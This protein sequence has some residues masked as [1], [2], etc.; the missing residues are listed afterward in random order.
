MEEERLRRLRCS[1]DA[2]RQQQQLQFLQQL[3]LRPQQQQ[4]SATPVRSGMSPLSRGNMGGKWRPIGGTVGPQQ[5]RQPLPG[6]LLNP[7]NG[8]F[9]N[10]ESRGMKCSTGPATVD[11]SSS[12]QYTS[13]AMTSVA[14]TITSQS[15]MAAP[16][17]S[18]QRQRPVISS[19]ALQPPQGA[20]TR[21]MGGLRHG[22]SPHSYI[23]PSSG[24]RRFY[25]VSVGGPEVFMP[26]GRN[27][28]SSATP[29][30]QL[31][32]RKIAS[33]K[34]QQMSNIVPSHNNTNTSIDTT[35]M[36]TN[37]NSKTRTNNMCKLSLFTSSEFLLTS[38][39]AGY[40]Q[41]RHGNMFRGSL[42]QQTPSLLDDIISGTSNLNL[43]EELT[44]IDVKKEPNSEIDEP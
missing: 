1:R 12:H 31:H 36:M 6:V 42:V 40:V 41:D 19:A 33:V 8:G 3:Q 26:T 16:P 37:C 7:V 13:P 17:T 43:K 2:S 23:S 44:D 34:Q 4:G 24:S 5:H 25:S 32:H 18:Q 10:T 20:E 15:R 28:A 38:T 29:I 22:L 9:S 39:T 11:S 27:P 14:S 21:L 30:V 35:S